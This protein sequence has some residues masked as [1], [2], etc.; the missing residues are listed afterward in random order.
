[1]QIESH[2][3][4]VSCDGPNCS[5]SVTFAATNEGSKEAIQDN[6]WLMSYRNVGTQDKRT[7][8][9]CSDACEVEATATGVHNI[10]EPKK[11][12]APGGQQGI[13]LAAKAAKQAADATAALKAGQNVTLG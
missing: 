9:Y 1:M 4:T 7:L 13:D 5:K 12:V 8:G 11:I 6:P 3:L 10:L 2:F